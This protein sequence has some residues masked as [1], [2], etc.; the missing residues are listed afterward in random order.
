MLLFSGVFRK[1]VSTLPNFE[2]IKKV[3]LRFTKT[4]VPNCKTDEQ[5]KQF[6]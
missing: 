5:G 3:I 6:F 4:L 2:D 1:Y